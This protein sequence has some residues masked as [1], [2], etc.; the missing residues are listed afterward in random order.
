MKTTNVETAERG[1]S[2]L[3]AYIRSLVDGPHGNMIH[4]TVP[5]GMVGRACHFRTIDEFWYVLS[6]EGEIW[7]SAPDGHESVTRLIPGVCLDIPVNE[8]LPGASAA[9]HGV[10]SSGQGGRSAVS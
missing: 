1:R 9:P 5:P 8:A 2:P 7:R 10:A 3:G 6:G 4:S